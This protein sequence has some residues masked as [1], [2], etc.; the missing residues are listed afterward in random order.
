MLVSGHALHV[1]S[2]G[3]D[4]SYADIG[5]DGSGTYGTGLSGYQMEVE[6]VGGARSWGVFMVFCARSLLMTWLFTHEF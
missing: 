3:R 4:V 1:L 6:H 5:Q 2:E